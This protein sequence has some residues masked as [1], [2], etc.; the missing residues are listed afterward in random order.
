MRDLKQETSLFVGILVFMSSWNFMLIW[1]EHKKKFYNIGAW[2]SGYGDVLL[3][4]FSQEEAHIFP[5][6]SV[7]VLIV[8]MY[9]VFWVWC[10]LEL[11]LA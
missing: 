9:V 5:T 3:S 4:L 6:L 11:Q 8:Y 10:V 7:L 1:V 2:L